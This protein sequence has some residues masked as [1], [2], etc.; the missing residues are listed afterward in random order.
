MMKVFKHLTIYLLILTIMG[1]SLM[2]P[3]IYLDFELRRDYI[4][5]VLCINRDEPITVC[6]GKCYLD[7]RLEQATEQQEQESRANNRPLEIYFFNEERPL[8]QFCYS[9]GTEGSP[10]LSYVSP[11]TPRTFTGD[12]FRPP[13][14]V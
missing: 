6:G 10:L 14:Q 13:Q 1:S 4:A 8:H 5:K 12:I 2:V 7:L 11:G 3:L 9:P